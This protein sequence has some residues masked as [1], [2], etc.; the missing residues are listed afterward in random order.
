MITGYVFNKPYLGPLRV[1]GY[2]QYWG[3]L[4]KMS[5]KKMTHV[6]KTCH[7]DV[8]LYGEVNPWLETKSSVDLGRGPNQKIEFFL[9][10]PRKEIWVQ[11]EPAWGGGCK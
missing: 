6:T 2:K 3:Y 10:E 5:E 9:R 11:G 8:D 7:V 4:G 1:H